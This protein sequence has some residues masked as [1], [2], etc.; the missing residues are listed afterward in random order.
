[1]H[2][3]REGEEGRRRSDCT[4]SPLCCSPPPSPSRSRDTRDP[5][6]IA[7]DAACAAG[8]RAGGHPGVNAGAAAWR[9]IEER[10]GAPAPSSAVA[11][12]EKRC[13]NPVHLRRC[14]PVRRCQALLLSLRGGRLRPFRHA[15]SPQCVATGDVGGRCVRRL[16]RPAPARGG[17][18]AQRSRWWPAAGSGRAA[19]AGLGHQSL[20]SRADKLCFDSARTDGSVPGTAA[21]R[22]QEAAASCPTVQLSAALARRPGAVR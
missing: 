9:G 1:M 5:L 19:R 14:H 15:A 12:D 7:A 21:A 20:S 3:G 13:G 11:L 10:R 16:P 22:L 4:P 6:P 18:G 8:A 17:T 2:F